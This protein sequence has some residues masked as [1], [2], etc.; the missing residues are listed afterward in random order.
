MTK[1]LNLN[2]EVSKSIIF[3]FFMKCKTNDQLLKRTSCYDIQV[4]DKIQISTNVTITECLSKPETRFILFDG[5][6]DVLLL[7]VSSHC[8]CHCNTPDIRNEC[9]LSGKMCSN[10]GNCHC[11]KC[12]CVE[13]YFGRYCE[14][15]III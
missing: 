7:N 11:G 3:E 5:L 6:H 13:D 10:H 12:E 8:K 1:S 2:F 9:I 15:V 4:G 14:L